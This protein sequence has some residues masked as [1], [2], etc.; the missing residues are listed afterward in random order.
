[1][2]SWQTEFRD[3][4]KTKVGIKHSFSVLLIPKHYY[5][6][7]IINML[8]SPTDAPE[9]CSFGVSWEIPL[10]KCFLPRVILDRV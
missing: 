1:M 10:Q 2:K 7:A 4:Y 9:D 6:V 5:A 8:C 3:A